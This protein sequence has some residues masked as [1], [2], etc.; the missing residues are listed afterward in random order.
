LLNWF[1]LSIIE[2]LGRGDGKTRS[3]DDLLRVTFR[4]FLL[5][6]DSVFVN[7]KKTL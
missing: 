3:K 7:S 4:F 2:N 5:T 6:Y 1:L